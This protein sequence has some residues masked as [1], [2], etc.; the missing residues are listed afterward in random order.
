M[1]R[2]LNL[3]PAVRPWT[4]WP[5]YHPAYVTIPER[6]SCLSFWLSATDAVRVCFTFPA[7]STT[8][9]LPSLHDFLLSLAFRDNSERV[10]PTTECCYN[11]VSTSIPRDLRLCLSL[12]EFRCDCNVIAENWTFILWNLSSSKERFFSLKLFCHICLGC[13]LD[14]S[15]F[16]TLNCILG[17]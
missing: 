6:T 9:C 11:I 4:P 1:R 2:T 10:A 3:L 5:L 16:C 8:V 14:Y 17:I 7:H 13:A 12:I 15:L